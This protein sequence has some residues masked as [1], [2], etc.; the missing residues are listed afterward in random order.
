MIPEYMFE[1]G[2]QQ[3]TTSFY[4]TD[5]LLV[6]RNTGIVIEAPHIAGVDLSCEYNLYGVDNW[7]LT[8]RG[9]DKFKI[10]QPEIGGDITEEDIQSII[11]HD[12]LYEE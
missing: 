4:A 8:L 5:V 9:Y 12:F 10:R 7:N 6:D 2:P 3:T 1:A 11:E